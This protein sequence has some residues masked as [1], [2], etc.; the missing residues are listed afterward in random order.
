MKVILIIG[1][2]VLVVA[3]IVYFV[4]N[5]VEEELYCDLPEGFTVTAHTGCEGTADNTL[6]SMRA[7]AFAGA[8][9]VEIDL[10]FMPDGT[11]VLC[12][13]EPKGK[14]FPTLDDAFALLKEL[15][16]KMNVD[17]KSA[18]DIPAVKS[19][20]EKHGVLDRI[21]F[22][23][24]EEE[25]VKAVKEGAPGTEYFLNV[26][27]DK[28]KNTDKAY[29]DSLIRKVKD[30][31]AVGINMNYKGCS[32]MLVEAF[33][34]EGLLVSL[35]TANDKKAMVRCC[36]YEPDNI[37]TRKPSELIELMASAEKK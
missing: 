31:G 21:F 15:E 16:V 23:G 17:V 33:R 37:T 25:K 19:L 3:L 18:A 9:I 26:G 34:E 28:K 20:A 5:K 36:Y 7:G 22:T 10:Q 13:N 2:V 30:C 4:N 6:E 29:I 24:V 27:V 1:L 11:P 14:K 35:W 8:D 32:K 12:H